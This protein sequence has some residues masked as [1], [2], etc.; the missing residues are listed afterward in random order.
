MQSESYSYTALGM[1]NDDSIDPN[2]IIVRAQNLVNRYMVCFDI[3]Y[4]CS[5]VR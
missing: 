4:T 1:S 2:M 5:R 3:G